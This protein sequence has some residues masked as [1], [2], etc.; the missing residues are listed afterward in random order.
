MET[1]ERFFLFLFFCFCFCFL[2]FLSSFFFLLSSLIKNLFS[3]EAGK[4]ADFEEVRKV[5]EEETQIVHSAIHQ[6]LRA[7]LTVV[8]SAP[9]FALFFFF[10][11]LLFSFHFLFIFFSF[12]CLF[13]FLSFLLIDLAFFESV[14]IKVI[15]KVFPHKSHSKEKQTTYLKNCLI[16]CEYCPVLLLRVL[17]FC[18]EKIVQ[19]DVEIV[20]DDVLE[21][22]DDHVLGVRK[23]RRRKRKKMCF[24]LRWKSVG[25]WLV[26]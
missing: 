19:I 6:A 16:I 11:N 23:R 2:L 21:E 1:E 17:Q 26:R 20:L 10:F 9:R 7:I 13:S 12:S 22:D 25:R 14:L 8:P 24:S 15:Q 3:L 18:I 5:N 4:Y